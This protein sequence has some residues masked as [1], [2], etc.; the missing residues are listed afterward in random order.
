MKIFSAGVLGTALLA[1]AMSVPGLAAGHATTIT[2]RVADLPS[3]GGTNSSGNS[4]NDRGWITGYSSLSGNNALHATLWRNGALTD[5]GTLGGP[6]SAVLWPVKDDGGIIT[7]I[8]QTSQ[9]DHRLGT[10]WSCA[11]FL[12]AATATGHRCVGFEWRNGVMHA[13]PTLGGPNGFATG[14]N[15]RGQIVGWAENRV[16]DPTCDSPQMLQFEAVMWSPGRHRVRVLPPLPGDT[17]GAATALNDRGQV[18][19]ISGYCDQ[20]VGRFSAIHAVLWQHGRPISIG[21]LGGVAWNTPMAINERGEVVGFSNVSAA[22]GGNF[23]AQAFLW[24]RRGGIRK[25][26]VL[27]GDSTSQALGINDRGEVVG[28][29]C[30]AKG[31]CR[32]FLYC[33]GKLQNLNSL[34][35]PGYAGTLV[36]AGDI[37]DAGVITGQA[38]TASGALVAFVADPQG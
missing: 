27:S 21:T 10:P 30:N 5:L 26:G 25:I 12:P 15:D 29:S 14:S 6:N 19:G 32:A 16:H 7:G 1:G 13:L 24:T 2:Y 20:A 9:P 37:N 35:A 33:D 3:L 38:Q 18:V 22:A 23:D 8:S 28:T 36:S 4:I 17:A 11:A 31:Q 34:V